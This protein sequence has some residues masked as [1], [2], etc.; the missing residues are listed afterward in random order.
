MADEFSGLNFFNSY[1]E[2]DESNIQGGATDMQEENTVS[3]P[4]G[5]NVP[6][7]IITP[8]DEA[9]INA[10]LGS[11][12]FAAAAAPMP[13]SDQIEAIAKIRKEAMEYDTDLRNDDAFE[14]IQKLRAQFTETFSLLNHHLMMEY[15]KA[16]VMDEGDNSPFREKH[17]RES[18][19]VRWVEYGRQNIDKALCFSRNGEL[20]PSSIT[21][22]LLYSIIR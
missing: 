8:E 10:L 11:D 9:T 20:S 19:S 12:I 16:I 1:G 4:A 18:N 21:I 3:E 17:L 15:N 2:E 5:A 6:Q 14:S 13:N 22:A 7:D